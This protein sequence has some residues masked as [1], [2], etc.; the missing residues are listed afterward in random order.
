M[1]HLLF[2][3]TTSQAGP[4][5]SDKKLGIAVLMSFVLI[6]TGHIM[7]GANFVVV[8]IAFT[9]VMLGIVPVN[10]TNSRCIGALF[11][12]V[13]AFRYVGFAAIAKLMMMQPL[14]SNLDQPIE[15][16]F[17]VLLGLAGYLIA[18]FISSIKSIGKPLLKPV[19]M[20]KKL[21]IISILG[22]LIGGVSWFGQIVAINSMAAGADL[23]RTTTIYSFFTSFFLLAI[24]AATA[25]AL[26][27]SNG[28]RSISAWCIVLLFAQLIFGFAANARMPILNGMLAYIL[29]LIAF[30]GKIR[31][32]YFILVC[33]LLSCIIS[34][35]TPI[36]LYVRG[37][38]GEL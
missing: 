11:I 5:V 17:A 25:Q 27:A 3:K 10:V 29:T 9:V 26:T 34:F 38:R 4:L 31:W 24:I 23:T 14:D 7:L 32:R 28:R 19:F 20:E 15:A 2:G 30:R 37:F 6:S 36:M 8:A 35:I 12:L 21:L 16:F 22:A 33:V 18:F 1:N 13:V